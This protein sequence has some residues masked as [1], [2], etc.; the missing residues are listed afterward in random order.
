MYKAVVL[1][2]LFAAAG[3]ARAAEELLDLAASA[4]SVTPENCRLQIDLESL[5]PDRKGQPANRMTVVLTRIGGRWLP[6]TGQGYRTPRADHKAD[7][8]ALA[9]DA[10]KLTGTLKVG[11]KPDGRLVKTW[12]AATCK[13]DAEITPV[14]PDAFWPKD[15][16][17]IRTWAY[18]FIYPRSQGAVW[19]VHGTYEGT[20]AGSKVAGKV[21]G[22]VNRPVRPGKWNMGTVENGALKLNFDLGTKRR[23]WNHGRVAVYQFPRVRDLSKF[24]G[25]RFRIATDKPRSDVE[26]TA[27]L[28]EA[29]GSWYHVK[30]AVPLTKE[31]NEAVVPFEDFVEADVVAPAAS[32]DENYRLDL[33]RI[34]HLAVGLINPFGLGK[35]SLR[36]EAV[37][38]IP[39]PKEAPPPPAPAR[40]TVTG[41]T[42]SLN[43]QLMIPCGLFGGYQDL[44]QEVRPGCMRHFS[45]GPTFP[46]ED[47]HEE[48]HIDVW[49]DRYQPAL[50]LTDADWKAKLIARGKAYAQKAKLAGYPARLELWNEPYLNWA[51]TRKNFQTKLFDDRQAKEGGPVTVKATGK[52]VPHFQWTRTPRGW[53]VIDATQ[54]TYYSAKGNSYLYDE[55]LLPLAKAVKEVY[56]NVQVLVSWGFR[57]KADHWTAWELEYKPS[58]DRCMP[59]IDGACEHH[60]GGEP[61]ALVGMYEVLTAYGV[62]QH[63]K[64]LYSYNTEAGELREIPVHGQIDTPRKAATLTQLRKAIYEVRDIMYCAAQ[65]PDKLRSRTILTWKSRAAQATPV[66]YGFLKNLRG[67]LVESDSSDKKVWCVTSIDG[68]DPKAMPRR[69]YGRSLVVALFNDHAGPR[70][71]ELTIAAPTDTVFRYGTTERLQVDPDTG[72][73]ALAAQRMKKVS[74][75]KQAFKLTLPGKGFWKTW[76]SLYPAPRRRRRRPRKGKAY[77]AEVMRQ[78]FFS[79]DILRAVGRGRLFATTVKL[80]PEILKAATR[81]WLRLVVE[82]IAPG[83][84][85]V[86]LGTK[87]ILLPKAVTSEN[88][89]RT[90]MIPVKPADLSPQTTFAFRVNPGNFAGYRVDMTS[91]VLETRPPA[92]AE[93]K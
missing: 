49:H 63:K 60:Y 34:S 78:Q 17:D 20:L 57:W 12:R 74:G 93:A 36:L 51:R 89:N 58:I 92:E 46:A 35:V 7:G 42:V 26:V 52:V 37:E 55:M 10:K 14:G 85:T 11:I 28:R 90:L 4:Q 9:L 30:A 8:A 70:D 45:G 13:L 91:I 62:T 77:P 87:E 56:P 38:T 59:Y 64:W 40:V 79:A 54:H 66:A 24:S 5:A 31:T 69:G 50:N 67:R 82:D 88:V 72:D 48:F 76:L 80:D 61:T 32:F 41:K 19:E 1:I 2:S 73:F 6:G 75:P 47:G 18:Y 81:A 43:G 23:N 33:K 84:A 22:F 65:V 16:I 25:L 15:D 21:T 29:D 71:V 86:R 3:H 39:L 68:T 44:P 53:E 27:Y 83:E